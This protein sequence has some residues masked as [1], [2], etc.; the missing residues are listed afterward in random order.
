MRHIY[1]LLAVLMFVSCSKSD[2]MVMRNTA[3][4]VSATKVINASVVAGAEYQMPVTSSTLKIFKQATNFEVSTVGVD[5]KTGLTVYKYIP[6]KGFTG[7]DEVTLSDSK[8][9][10]ST[11][12]GCSRSATEGYQMPST[13]T[14]TYIKIKFA[15]AN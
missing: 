9:S 2:E 7:N 3:P 1:T 14:T 4:E 8:T 15:V 11:G 6:A 13:T 5:A 12:S 10:V